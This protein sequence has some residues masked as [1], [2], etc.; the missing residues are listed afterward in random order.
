MHLLNRDSSEGAKSTHIPMIEISGHDLTRKTNRIKRLIGFFP[1]EL[2]LFPTFSAWDKSAFFSL[3]RPSEPPLKESIVALGLLL[4]PLVLYLRT[5]APDVL[6]GDSALFQY[7]PR[8]LAVTYPTGYPLYIL[9]GKL[10]TPLS[11]WATSL[12][13]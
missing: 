7:A 3:I 2:A 11:L 8:A 10:W 9:L 1:Q 13:A 6:D 5:M 4:A 12:I